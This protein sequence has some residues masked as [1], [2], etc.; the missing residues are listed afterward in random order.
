MPIQLSQTTTKNC[1]C[2]KNYFLLRVCSSQLDSKDLVHPSRFGAWMAAENLATKKQIKKRICGA[3]WV[4]CQSRIFPQQREIWGF[5]TPTS[6]EL[7]LLK[8]RIIQ[9]AKNNC[10]SLTFIYKLTAENSMVN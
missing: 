10:I 7:L 2:F 3:V 4:C 8:F 6:V 5:F 9:M 1:Y